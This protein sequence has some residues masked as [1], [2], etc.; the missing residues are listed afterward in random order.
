MIIKSALSDKEIINILKQNT[1]YHSPVLNARHIKSMK[2]DKKLCGFIKENSLLIWKT[3]DKKAVIVPILKCDV[4]N[5]EINISADLPI[6][7][8]Y[9]LTFWYIILVLYILFNMAYLPFSVGRLMYSVNVIIGIAVF[10][11]SF[12]WKKRL[13]SKRCKE[14]LKVLEEAVSLKR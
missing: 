4:E 2:T 11:I 8:K 9:M 1:F 14:T 13:F 7:N 6:Q 5:G 10:F 12:F 3:L